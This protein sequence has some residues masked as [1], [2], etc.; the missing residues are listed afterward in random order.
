[1]W[2]CSFK[3]FKVRMNKNDNGNITNS[4]NK[5][6]KKINEYFS[7]IAEDLKSKNS[8]EV[9]S[10]HNYFEEYLGQGASESIRLTAVSQE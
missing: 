7:N 8:S 2:N 1:M 5:I 4:P 9:H 6:L 3:S 10:D